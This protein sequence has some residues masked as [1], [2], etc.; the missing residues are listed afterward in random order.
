MN[1]KD[2]ILNRIESDCDK[3]CKKIDDEAQQRCDEILNNARKTAEKEKAEVVK[4]TESRL[5]QMK[6]SS[7]SRAQL[8]IRNTLLK[9]RREEIDK[10]VDGV[11]SYLLSLGDGEYFELL[12]KLA[13]KLPD[14]DGEVMLNQKDLDRLPSDFRSRL[15][16]AG[17][18]ATVCS[19]PADIAGG[20]IFKKG[21]IE[22]NLSFS[23]IIASNRDSLEDY[24]NRALF[25][26]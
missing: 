26:Q 11:M 20:M 24:I 16:A 25:E 8:E 5:A 7:E 15:G 22:E 17:L 21:N 6:A 19:Q 2:K 10:T 4:K 14:S 9:K 18:N 3:I 23:A 12:Y 1:S 13:S